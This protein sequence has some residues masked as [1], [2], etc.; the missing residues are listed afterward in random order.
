MVMKTR[1]TSNV[2]LL[3]LLLAVAASLMFLLS[4]VVRKNDPASRGKV[5]VD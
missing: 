2:R 5:V 1:V 3:P 4:F